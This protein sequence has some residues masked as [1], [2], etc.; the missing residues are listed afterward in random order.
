[1]GK[2]SESKGQAN[3]KSNG[4]RDG[5]DWTP[6][7][8]A[9]NKAKKLAEKAAKAEASSPVGTSPVTF[10]KAPMK[11]VGKIAHQLAS[12]AIADA[13]AKILSC[14]AKQIA[15]KKHSVSPKA[16]PKSAQKNGKK[17]PTLQL[18]DATSEQYTEEFT[19]A[20]R[21][22]DTT[23]SQSSQVQDRGTSA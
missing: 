20:R 2:V 7:Q 18:G 6:E 8:K 3:S 23:V 17:V 15:E 9:A 4:Q 5:N 13:T 14:G 10:D 19:T 1:M 21:A 16:S 12:D 11:E 22:A